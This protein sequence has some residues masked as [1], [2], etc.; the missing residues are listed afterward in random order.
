M[1][2]FLLQLREHV[3]VLQG[4]QLLTIPNYLLHTPRVKLRLGML[5][6][7][8]RKFLIQNIVMELQIAAFQNH[9][10]SFSSGDTFLSLCFREDQELSQLAVLCKIK[11]PLHLPNESLNDQ[12]H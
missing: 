8:Q 6:P 5:N 1:Y 11:L 12:M 7:E 3:P 9:D 2:W 10:N 4:I